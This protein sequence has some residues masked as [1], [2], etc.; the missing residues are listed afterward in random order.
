MGKIFR[1]SGTH[2]TMN[3]QSTGMNGTVLGEQGSPELVG[4]RGNKVA[5]VVDRGKQV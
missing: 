3:P 5:E 2:L 1:V 4:K